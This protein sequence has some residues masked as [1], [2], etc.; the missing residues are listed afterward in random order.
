VL[1]EKTV[2]QQVKIFLTYKGT[3]RFIISFRYARQSTP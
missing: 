1:L 3:R 2:V